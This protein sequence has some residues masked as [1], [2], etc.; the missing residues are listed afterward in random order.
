MYE[1]LKQINPEVKVLLSSGYSSEDK[2]LSRLISAGNPFIH[3]PYSLSEL[4]AAVEKAGLVPR[5]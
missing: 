3:K 4:A 1:A 2:A 5:D